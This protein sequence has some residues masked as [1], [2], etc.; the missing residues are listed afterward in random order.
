MQTLEPEARAPQSTV[1][2][3]EA[4]VEKVASTPPIDDAA[5]LTPA[6]A[7]PAVLKSDPLGESNKDYMVLCEPWKQYFRAEPKIL[8]L[9]RPSKGVLGLL[10]EQ[11]TLA[12]SVLDV[13][14]SV[15][16]GSDFAPLEERLSELK[17]LI[18]AA[19]TASGY[20]PYRRGSY[21]YVRGD[22]IY[23]RTRGYYYDGYFYRY[24]RQKQKSSSPELVRSV[25]GIVHN[26]S[27]DLKDLDQRVDALQRMT[28]QWSRRTASM[29]TTGT[30]GIMREANE[31]Y[32]ESLKHF[33]Q[34]LIAL[35]TAVRRAHEEQQEIAAN[36]VS[37]LASWEQFETNHLPIIQDY[38]T[39]NADE[40]IE[41]S[42]G[43]VYSLPD[44][45]SSQ[46]LILVCRIGGRDLYFEL[47]T[48]RSDKHPFVMVDVTPNS[49]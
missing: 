48:E 23:T 49:D 2:E 20:V 1:V 10:R 11:Q 12:K 5:E 27:L 40:I 37:I 28:S 25:E 42:D 9:N 36:K 13:S 3:I 4:P 39:Q 21:T 41:A 38:L 6:P 16:S 46:Q 33:T 17:S 35:R 30:S 43:G 15:E 31:A 19:E 32:L 8:I 14:G 7:P 29:S 24:L 26:A 47:S 44:L 22:T 18:P 45:R 34:E